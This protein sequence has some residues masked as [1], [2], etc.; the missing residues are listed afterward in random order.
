[1]SECAYNNVVK[2]STIELD[3]IQIVEL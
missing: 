1:M 3:M 2:K